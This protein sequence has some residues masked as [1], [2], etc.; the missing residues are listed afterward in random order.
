[1][2]KTSVALLLFVLPIITSCSF[3]PAPLSSPNSPASQYPQINL[4]PELRI[5]GLVTGIFPPFTM[6]LWAS[7][8]I[9]L[10]MQLGDIWNPQQNPPAWSD[11]PSVAIKLDE[12]P[13]AIEV[14]SYT[15]SAPEVD[16]QG[17]IIKY[18]GT[19][20]YCFSPSLRKGEHMLSVQ[21]NAKPGLVSIYSWRFLH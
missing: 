3:N 12:Q 20:N 8:R 10:W 7:G 4:K 2:L 16:K 18:P 6:E 17:L 13:I 14:T 15:S 5:P 9:C 11:L 1:M 21:I 19:S